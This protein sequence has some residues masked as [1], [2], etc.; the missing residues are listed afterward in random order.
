MIEKEAIKKTHGDKGGRTTYGL[1]SWWIRLY[2]KSTIF[3]AMKMAFL[4]N[5][6]ELVTTSVYLLWNGSAANVIMATFAEARLCLYECLVVSLSTFLCLNFFFIIKKFIL[7][8]T[9]YR[10]EKIH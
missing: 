8:R 10:E 7:E 9:T 4:G 2:Q 1:D 5:L 3:S 6:R